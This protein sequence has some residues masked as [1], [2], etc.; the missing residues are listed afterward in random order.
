MIKQQKRRQ[1]IRTVELNQNGAGANLDAALIGVIE[2]L[3]ECNLTPEHEHYAIN[4][5][6]V[7]KYMRGTRRAQIGNDS[8]GVKMSEVL[9]VML[10]I[11]GNMTQHANGEQV[12]ALL[13]ENSRPE[14]RYRNGNT[15]INSK[16][17]TEVKHFGLRVGFRGKDES[18]NIASC[19]QYDRSETRLYTQGDG[20]QLTHLDDL[21]LFGVEA[22][23]PYKTR[24]QRHIEKMID[25]AA[26][27]TDCEWRE[28]LEIVER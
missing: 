18:Q 19:L 12:K 1:T 22:L 24:K 28:F 6:K 16:N 26:T 7:F 13:S 14:K 17:A 5:I 27:L 21:L 11:Y 4:I 10:V 3:E 15:K 25:Y 20:E 2:Q 8:Q 23:A 9:A